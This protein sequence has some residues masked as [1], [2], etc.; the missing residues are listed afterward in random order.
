MQ[1]TDLWRRWK[2]GHSLHQIGRA[3]GKSHVSIRFWLSQHG[4]IVP[5]A[6]RRSLFTL[7]LAE[8]KNISRGIASGA[9]IRDLAKGLRRAAPTVSREISRHG[10][11]PL[12]EPMKPIARPGGR[13]YD[14]K[15][16]FWPFT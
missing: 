14:P 7:T 3:F 8:R 1:K 11:R 10:G 15:R 2:A 12:I 5:A 9:S 4:G 13:P 6:R 16:A